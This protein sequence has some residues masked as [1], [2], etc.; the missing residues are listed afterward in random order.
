ML[1]CF[2]S[3]CLL[4]SFPNLRN[5]FWFLQKWRRERGTRDKWQE[6]P[7]LIGLPGSTVRLSGF[8]VFEML[9]WVLWR[10]IPHHWRSLLVVHSG[11][12][13]RMPFSMRVSVRKPLAP[14][15]WTSSPSRWPLGAGFSISPG[16]LSCVAHAE[17]CLGCFTPSFRTEVAPFVLR[18]WILQRQDLILNCN[19]NPVHTCLLNFNLP[20]TFEGHMC[21]EI[22]RLNGATRRHNWRSIRLI[23]WH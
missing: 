17:F 22:K 13:L 21:M 14:V 2:P 12:A 19:N 4:I 9:L 6:R 1:L 16:W 5:A 23:P 8:L 20:S 7:Y 3:L 18:S 11:W 10:T 15:C